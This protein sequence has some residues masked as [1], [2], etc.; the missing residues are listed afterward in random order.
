MTNSKSKIS[1]KVFPTYQSEYSD[2]V[3]VLEKKGNIFT[4][5][6]IFFGLSWMIV[7]FFNAII[8]VIFLVIWIVSVI[9]FEILNKELKRVK[10]ANY[11]SETLTQKLNDILTK[12]CEIVEIILPHFEQTSKKN[13]EIAKIDFAENAIAPFWDRIEDTSKSLAAFAEAVEQLNINGEIYTKILKTKKHNFPIPFP[14]GLKIP[15]PEN[16]INELNTIV[17]KGQSKFEFANIW[18]HRKTQ[19]ILIAGF[20]T[21]EQAINNMRDTIVSAINNLNSSM[22]SEFRESRKIQ[23]EMINSFESSQQTISNTLN[24][25]DKKLYYMEYNKKPYTPFVRPLLD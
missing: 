3:E 15:F 21:L 16:I 12:S 8:G 4:A 11:E 10:G 24:S 9:T 22:K 25:M 17:R 6:S 14:Y 20:S 5:L 1:Y 13:I 18:E 23:L 7:I 19:K 2:K